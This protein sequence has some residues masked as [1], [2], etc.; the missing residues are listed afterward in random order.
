[1]NTKLPAFARV[2]DRLIEAAATVA[3]SMIVFA[4]LA[5]CGGIV[6]RYFFNQPQT[7]VIDISAILLLYI[8][9]L[10]AAWLLRLDAHVKVDLLLKPLHPKYQSFLNI[11]T[12]II[13]L[14]VFLVITWY[15]AKA[16]WINFEMGYF[17]PTQLE[18]PKWIVIVIIPVGAFFLLIQL[19]RRIRYLLRKQA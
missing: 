1:M 9:F 17:L 8:T 2:F 16:A 12:S 18:T 19:L 10:A 13:S 6:M 14:A 15:G 11:I 5:V 4:M 7:W 3:A